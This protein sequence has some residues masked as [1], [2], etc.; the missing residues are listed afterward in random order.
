MKLHEVEAL[1]AQL[2]GMVPH[3]T[4]FDL[5]A[6]YQC[7]S[8]TI[9]RRSKSGKFPKPMRSGKTPLWPAEVILKYESQ[10]QAHP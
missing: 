6:R 4:A 7:H 8:A 3:F 9:L 2:L 5:A 10:A 1:A